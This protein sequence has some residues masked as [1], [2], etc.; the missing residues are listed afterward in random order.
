MGTNGN[1]GKKKYYFDDQHPRGA[2]ESRP[3]WIHQRWW[4]SRLAA[5]PLIPCGKIPDH[6]ETVGYYTPLY[7]GQILGHRCPVCGWDKPVLVQEGFS[8]PC[9]PVTPLPVTLSRAEKQAEYRRQLTAG[10]KVKR[11]RIRRRELRLRVHRAWGDRIPDD[12]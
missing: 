10:L 7:A 12:L 6:G 1:L 8:D 4:L 11:R 3:P 2:L 5:L 9:P